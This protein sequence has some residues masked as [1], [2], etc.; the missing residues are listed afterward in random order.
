[1]PLPPIQNSKTETDIALL[2]AFCL[3]LSAIEYLIPKP[4]PFMRIGLANLP[5]LLALRFP[6][7]TFFSLMLIKIFGQ[8]LISGTLFSYVFLFSFAGT[9]IAAPAMFFFRRIASPKKISFVG[10]SITGAFLSNLTQLILARYFI[11]GR[12]ALYLAPVFLASGIV[13]GAA[14]GIFCEI[15]SS[16]SQW[17]KGGEHPPPLPPCAPL[18]RPLPP[19][20]G[21]AP[22]QRPPLA[23]RL[24][25]PPM[26]LFVAGILMMAMLL[27]VE[28]TL[29]RVF[30]FLLFWFF[31]ALCGK[32]GKP[33][34]TIVFFASI[35]I[36]NV[37][38]P[39][40]KVLF[41]LGGLRI[42]EGALVNGA[43]KAASVQALLMI[44]RATIQANLPIPGRAG[45][46]LNR[47]FYIFE[48]IRAA[49]KTIHAKTIM[50]DIDNLLLNLSAEPPSPPP[51]SHET[52]NCS[53]KSI[54]SINS[55]NSSNSVKSLPSIKSIAALL[56]AL[57]LTALPL[58]W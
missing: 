24:A 49:K 54:N 20:A 17:Y 9:I 4:L 47:S 5:L 37:I 55:T 31:A 35:V 42:T 1:M 27:S 3:F 13:S 41:E 21:G 43:R 16:Q 11:L 8:A 2:G 39:H 32:A 45:I 48:K 6:F 28:S 12:G 26:C 53:D 51:A 33:L 7:K 40:G 56:A 50:R 57:A 15:F 44:S 10:I 58:F 19:P 23:D 14:L 38:T 30:Q 18:G 34:I 25:I 29:G 36:V 52:C 46:L 22:P